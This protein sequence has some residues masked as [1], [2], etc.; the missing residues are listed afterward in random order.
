MLQI[1]GGALDCLLLVQP[2]KT[3]VRIGSVVECLTGDGK[4][5]RHHCLVFLSKTHYFLLGT[6]SIKEDPS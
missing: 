5:Q 4:P 6:G 2:R 3:G 1:I